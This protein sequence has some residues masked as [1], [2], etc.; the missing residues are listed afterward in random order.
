M[1]LSHFGI[2]FLAA[3]PSRRR[4]TK[5]VQ[6]WRAG[7]D[8]QGDFQRLEQA[9]RF[10]QKDSDLLY[11]QRHK[12]IQQF[13]KQRQL[14]RPFLQRKVVAPFFVSFLLSF[15]SFPRF[16]HRLLHVQFLLFVCFPPIALLVLLRKRNYQET[17]DIRQCL[18]EQWATAV[19]GALFLLLG[20]KT[21]AIMRLSALCAIRQF[22]RL[23]CEL[24]ETPR[25]VDA[26]SYSLQKAIAMLSSPWWIA[27]EVSLCGFP[28]SVYLGAASTILLFYLFP[29][30]VQH[31]S[32]LAKS[33]VLGVGGRWFMSNQDTVR[34]IVEWLATYGSLQNRMTSIL[35][36]F[37]LARP[38]IVTG[39]A[40]LGSVIHIVAF[41]KLIQV[42]LSNNVSLDMDQKQMEAALE[43]PKRWYV[44][45]K[46]REPKRIHTIVRTWKDEWIYNFLFA[47]SVDEQLRQERERLL[48]KQEL[49]GMKV[50]QRIEPSNATQWRDNA[51]KRMSGQHHRDYESGTF[52]VSIFWKVTWGAIPFET[53]HM[54]FIVK[55]PL[56]VAV[57][58]T[59]GIGLG[60]NFDHM[61][62]SSTIPET[63]RL[64]A[65]AAK[66][67]VRRVQ[68]L[69]GTNSELL[70]NLPDGEEK[71]K[72]TAE[73]KA[74]IEQETELLAKRLTE[75]VPLDLALDNPNATLVGQMDI[76]NFERVSSH[77]YVMKQQGVVTTS[78]AVKE[79]LDSIAGNQT[80]DEELVEWERQL[81]TLVE[82]EEDNGTMATYLA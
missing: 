61:S 38:Y 31:K 79:L 63:R 37:C 65:R 13:P 7:Q 58:K 11:W 49:E 19:A 9:I 14:W 46:W 41:T 25:P 16:F 69:Y 40:C 10:S 73:L 17:Q 45:T 35:S 5:H 60:F 24:N 59:L 12:R 34:Y 74:K 82:D 71:L 52:E 39:M 2:L 1:I 23:P 72:K 43:H 3:A 6:A 80:E 33:F 64:Q 18:L 42:N 75:L 36:L 57:Y 26:L 68:D 76:S 55:D 50:W 8:V 32:V 29:S 27:A 30:W 47:G 44:S 20:P 70:K 54:A 51:M 15:V 81:T 21:R 78:R 4:R 62:D 22:P 28:P 56:G 77:E 48:R 53:T 67:A 66:S